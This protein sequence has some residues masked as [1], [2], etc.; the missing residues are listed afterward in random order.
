ML[1]GG[2]GAADRGLG[3]VQAGRGPGE[4]ALLGDA[5]HVAELM[6]LHGSARAYMAIVGQ[7]KPILYL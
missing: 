4:P 2:H 1:E 6:Q 7:R 3:H 5:H